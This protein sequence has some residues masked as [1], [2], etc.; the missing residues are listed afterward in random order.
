M[1]IKFIE[2]LKKQSIFSK[3]SIDD[4]ELLSVHSEQV[5]YEPKQYLCKKGNDALLVYLN[6]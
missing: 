4:L 3:L 5:N 2:Q 6:L 1:T